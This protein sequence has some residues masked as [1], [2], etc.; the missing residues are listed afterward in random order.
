MSA[1]TLCN[2]TAFTASLSGRFTNG[3]IFKNRN[4]PRLNFASSLRFARRV[5][6]FA[7]RGRI[8]LLLLFFFV[9]GRG[10]LRA[11][12]QNPKRERTRRRSL[13]LAERNENARM[14][15]FERTDFASAESLVSV[16]ERPNARRFR[17][18][19]FFFA[20]RPPFFFSILFSLSLS[21]PSF[22]KKRER[23]VSRDFRSGVARDLSLSLSLSLV[24]FTLTP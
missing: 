22:L 1:T 21:L 6:R 13:S 11:R 12:A 8:L 16:R 17:G 4:L 24:A 14:K 15:T 3:R 9:R 18:E 19:I 10:K 20:F 2:S 5:S 7:T 23:L